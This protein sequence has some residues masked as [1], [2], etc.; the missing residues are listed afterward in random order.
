MTNRK[1]R[2]MV[3]SGHLIESLIIAI[4]IYTTASN[5]PAFDAVV[6]FI[7]LPALTISGIVLWRQP[8]ILKL[9]KRR[10]SARS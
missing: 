1:F 10:A 4:Y 7:F 5:Y 9:F 6:K 2:A 3:R 8:Q